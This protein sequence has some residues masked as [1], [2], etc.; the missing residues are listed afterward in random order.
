MT[1]IKDDQNDWPF[2]TD[3][4]SF[5]ELLGLAPVGE[6]KGHR[7]THTH[8]HTNIAEWLTRRQNASHKPRDRLPIDELNQ[9]ASSQDPSV[10]GSG[11]VPESDVITTRASRRVCFVC[12][13]FD[14]R[15]SK[16][17]TFST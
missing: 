10:S 15:P 13:C 14:M 9:R 17:N 8:I 2:T 7:E 6:K 4:R 3:T 5:I 16:Y 11:V 12:V 1:D